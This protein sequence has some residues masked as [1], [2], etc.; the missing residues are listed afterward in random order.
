MKYS[1]N[2]NARILNFKELKSWAWNDQNINMI[3]LLEHSF[4][5]KKSR[6]FLKQF[7]L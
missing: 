5:K 6:V 3:S 4:F 2:V 1:K 7:A